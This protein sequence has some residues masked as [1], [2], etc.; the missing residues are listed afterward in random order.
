M[1]RKYIIAIVV[2]AVACIVISSCSLFAQQRKGNSEG[3]K[4]EFPSLPF[5]SYE[6]YF[7]EQTNNPNVFAIGLVFENKSSLVFLWDNT[8][9]SIVDIEATYTPC[10]LPTYFGTQPPEG[11]LTV[12]QLILT[13][14]E[15]SSW[16]GNKIVPCNLNKTSNNTYTFDY[17]DGWGAYW[18][19][20]RAIFYSNNQ[21]IRW[22]LHVM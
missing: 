18:L 20:G 19:Y 22:V 11:Y 4:Q 5:T 16:T 2:I 15:T 10:D 6:I 21:T 1:E 7:C 17:Y 13:K 14:N 12:Y 9:N 3:T 8:T